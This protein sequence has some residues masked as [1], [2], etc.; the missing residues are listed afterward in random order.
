MAPLGKKPEQQNQEKNKREKRERKEKEARWKAKKLVF[1][2]K[3]LI[4]QGF[5]DSKVSM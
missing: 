4:L 1:E 5:Q 2:P 3:I